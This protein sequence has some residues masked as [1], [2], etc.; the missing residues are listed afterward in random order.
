MEIQQ[1]V[2]FALLSNYKIFRTATIYTGKVP[3]IFDRSELPTCEVSRKIF[4][5][6]HQYQISRKSVYG[7][8]A[9]TDGQ[10]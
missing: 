5:E 10:T 9:D 8:Y 7:K 6:V 2:P 4:V 1:W 3:G